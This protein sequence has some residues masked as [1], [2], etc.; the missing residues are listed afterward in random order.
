M[1]KPNAQYWRVKNLCV[2]FE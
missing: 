1:E 2:A